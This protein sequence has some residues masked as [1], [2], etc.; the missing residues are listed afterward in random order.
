MNIGKDEDEENGQVEG[1]DFIAEVKKTQKRILS[2]KSKPIF[3]E[4][5]K[6]KQEIEFKTRALK[7]KEADAVK[8]QIE[9]IEE[10]KKHYKEIL[11]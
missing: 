11:T 2:S 8:N 7:Q 5:E 10:T 9:S 3:D 6:L 4:V 1:D